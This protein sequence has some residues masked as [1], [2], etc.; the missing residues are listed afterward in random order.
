MLYASIFIFLLMVVLNIIFK[1][2][3]FFR[4]GIP[5]IYLLA[6]PILF[7]DWLHENEILAAGILYALIGLVILSWVIT[8]RKRIKL[9]R[10][11]A[12]SDSTIDF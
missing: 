3:S 11:K 5:L 2:A 6:V 1:I 8:I 4:L 10:Q 12:Q 7:P 9:K